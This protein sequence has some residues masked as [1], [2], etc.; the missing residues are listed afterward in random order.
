MLALTRYTVAREMPS[1]PT[2]LLRVCVVATA[3]ATVAFALLD[4]V[5]QGPPFI[6][7]AGLL[8][9]VAIGVVPSLVY[10]LG[11]RRRQTSVVYGLVL[12]AATAVAWLPAPLLSVEGGGGMEYTFVLP[13]FLLT[14]VTSSVATVHDR[15]DRRQ[16]PTDESA[17]ART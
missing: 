15:R 6:S 5:R 17:E 4:E 9:I 14:L 13:V 8:L 11:V 2:L 3:M 12:V 1:V 16:T 7:T 10:L